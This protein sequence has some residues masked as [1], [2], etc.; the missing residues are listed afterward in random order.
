[1]GPPSVPKENPQR[2]VEWVFMGRTASCHTTINDTA[3]NGMQILSPLA[4]WSHSFFI[5]GLPMEGAL[6]ILRRRSDDNTFFVTLT[7]AKEDNLTMQC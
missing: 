7:L 2:L 4:A 5:T 1:M 6:L 3:L